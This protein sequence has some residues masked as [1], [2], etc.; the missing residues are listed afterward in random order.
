M[1][2]ELTTWESWGLLRAKPESLGTSSPGSKTPESEST[3]AGGAAPGARGGGRFIVRCSGSEGL[4]TPRAQGPCIVQA[5]AWG[6]GSPLG[7]SSWGRGVGRGAA[8]IFNINL[9]MCGN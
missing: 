7:S 4:V 2:E 6:L 5:W 9:E 3:Q 1:S 8:I